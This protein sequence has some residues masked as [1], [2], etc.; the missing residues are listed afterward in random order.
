MFT[1]DLENYPY[2][3]QFSQ[4]FKFLF[5]GQFGHLGLPFHL[6]QQIVEGVTKAVREIVGLL[7]VII[8]SL[9]ALEIHQIKDH[10]THTDAQ[11]VIST[12]SLRPFVQWLKKSL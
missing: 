9:T 10:A 8:M 11:L 2:C 5:K 3:S 12:K 7:E 4:K 1:C 6:V